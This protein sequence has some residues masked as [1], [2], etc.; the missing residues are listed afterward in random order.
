MSPYL[1]V[2]FLV[3]MWIVL[4]VKMR[5]S[6]ALKLAVFQRHENLRRNTAHAQWR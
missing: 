2:V 5:T 1:L 6:P 4:L 3:D